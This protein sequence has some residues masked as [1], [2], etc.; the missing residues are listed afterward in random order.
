MHLNE[1]YS[2]PGVYKP[3]QTLAPH[4][5]MIFC[6]E[7]VM[8]AWFFHIKLGNLTAKDGGILGI[9]TVD[10]KLALGLCGLLDLHNLKDIGGKK[11]DYFGMN[12]T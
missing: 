2:V 7:M 1:L 12:R 8:K 6:S 4:G 5:M 3:T 11:A 10:C 9:S